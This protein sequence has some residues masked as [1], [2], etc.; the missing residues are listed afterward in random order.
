MSKR[1][2]LSDFY[3]SLPATV[4]YPGKEA[5]RDHVGRELGARRLSQRSA[6]SSSR[7]DL[8]GLAEGAA[9]DLE[10]ASQGLEEWAIGLD[11]E[12]HR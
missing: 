10:L 6:G 8:E 5:V 4:A 12:D 11:E 7:W 3:G 2:G 1:Q 9:E